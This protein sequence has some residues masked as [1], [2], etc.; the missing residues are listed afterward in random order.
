MVIFNSSDGSYDMEIIT[1]PNIGSYQTD[2]VSPIYR[3]DYGNNNVEHKVDDSYS[4]SL[5]RKIHFN[6]QSIIQNNSYILNIFLHTKRLEGCTDQTIDNYR[7]T[8]KNFMYTTLKPFNDITTLDC[9]NYLIEYKDERNISNNTLDDMRRVLNTFFKFLEEEDFI[10]RS[11]MKK[12]HRIKGEKV[13]KLPFTEEDIERIRDACDTIRDLALIDFLN[14]SGV[15]VGELKALDQDD[16]DLVNR[17]GIVYG[18]GNKERIIYIDSKCKVHLEKYLISRFDRNPAL[19]VSERKP[20][21]RLTKAGIE[22]IVKRIGN[23]AGVRNAH[24][25]RFRRSLATRLI[26]KNVPIEQVQRILGHSKI[27]TTLIYAEVSQL[28]IKINHDKFAT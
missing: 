4:G 2:N 26:K 10:L 19:F 7:V 5:A 25:H 18:K 27:E 24:P 17:E 21:G 22:D 6:T 12:V 15:R 16:V 11:P 3:P 1:T 23:K 14:S 13:V 9:R 20:F 28:D 8:L